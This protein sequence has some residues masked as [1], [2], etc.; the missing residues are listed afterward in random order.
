MPDDALQMKMVEFMEKD[1]TPKENPLASAVTSDGKPAEGGSK[2]YDVDAANDADQVHIPSEEEIEYP[3]GTRPAPAAKPPETSPPAAQADEGAKEGE[4]DATKPTTPSAETAPEAEEYDLPEEAMFVVKADGKE[5]KVSGKAIADAWRRHQDLDKRFKEADVLKHEAEK[6]AGMLAAQYLHAAGYIDEQGRP[7]MVA[8]QYQ[9]QAQQ[10]QAPGAAPQGQPAQPGKPTGIQL[11]KFNYKDI[12]EA[13]RW[14]PDSFFE[15][16][17][18]QNEVLSQH[19]SSV[20]ERLE[21]LSGAQA[22]AERQTEPTE[23]Q[24]EAWKSGVKSKLGTSDIFT[25]NEARLDAGLDAVI[26]LYKD[27]GFQGPVDEAV[28]VVLA[29]KAKEYGTQ[30]SGAPA[31]QKRR[32]PPVAGMTGQRAPGQASEKPKAMPRFGS[33]SATEAIREALL[34]HSQ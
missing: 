34:R 5:Q 2:L 32:M 22:P 26:S 24:V 18:Q 4:A 28:K 27:R 31:P 11:P 13:E 19:L 33:N 17:N 8:P 3:D 25:G 15:A 14:L 10:A 6:R 21:R 29:E 12:P 16:W 1:G 23:A 7:R 20:N 9:Q 30:A